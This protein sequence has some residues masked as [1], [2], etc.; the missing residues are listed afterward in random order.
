MGN[1]SIR[2][3]FASFLHPRRLWPSRVLFTAAAALAS[4]VI[5]L[6]ARAG[7]AAAPMAARATLTPADTALLDEIEK[8]AV[9]FFI[10]HSDPHT[11]LTEDRARNRPDSGHA[12]AS[13]AATGFG[14]SAWCIADSRGWLPPGEAVV[15]VRRTLRF[16]ADRLAQEH[17]WFYHFVDRK[18]GA[19]AGDSEAST[20][21]TAL[22]MQGALF[23]REYLRDPETTALVDRIYA[24]IDWRWAL[25][26]GLTLTH[27][28]RPETGF[29]SYRWDHYSELMGLYL[30]GLGA[31]NDPLPAASWS[32]WRREPLAQFAGRTFIQCGP[33]FTHQYAQGW[34]DFRGQHDAFAD[35]WQ[36][37]IDATLAQRAW[38]AGQSARFPHWSRDMWGLTA[39][40]GA[41]GYKAWGTPGPA[42]DQSDGTLVPCAPA[43]SL[44]F[45]PRECLTALHRMRAT[46]GAGVWGRYGFTDAFNPETGWVSPDVIGIDQGITL[47]MAENLR[48]GLVWK[49]FMRAEEVQRGMQR[50]GFVPNRDTPTV[51]ATLQEF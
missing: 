15:Q 49:N 43:G 21:D 13:V 27:G 9:L 48:T 14:L 28:W 45:A 36:N 8:R 7:V 17:G 23:A 29:I 40:D 41:D 2:A 22:F 31:P 10:E 4:M 24:R 51:T 25:H 18:T 33:L 5:V 39:S 35:Y 42:A 20:I 12:V 1:K 32:A 46:G 34:F 38:S 16:A 30:I 44:P 19:R 3:I 47:V 11:G 37:S 26:G 6:P 50:A